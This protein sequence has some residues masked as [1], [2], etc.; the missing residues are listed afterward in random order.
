MS[1]KWGSLKG[2]LPESPVALFLWDFFC[3]CKRRVF[4]QKKKN[5]PGSPVGI[6]FCLL[7]PHRVRLPLFPAA[8]WPSHFQKAF[9]LWILQVNEYLFCFLLMKC[10][11]SA[12]LWAETLFWAATSWLLG[13]PGWWLSNRRGCSCAF[14]PC[15]ES[16][17]SANSLFFFFSGVWTLKGFVFL[18]T[19]IRTALVWE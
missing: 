17:T 4:N 10:I 6:G 18:F 5:H 7:W 9:V 3:V 2:G 12:L 14:F 15:W 16:L 11:W 8:C 19:K 13:D 1:N